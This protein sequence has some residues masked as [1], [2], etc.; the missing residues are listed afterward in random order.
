MKYVLPKMICTK[1]NTIQ[2]NNI[3][4]KC[5]NC[6]GK[7]ELYE[8]AWFGTKD[9]LLAKIVLIILAI[10]MIIY[11][12]EYFFYNHIS[13]HPIHLIAIVLFIIFIIIIAKIRTNRKQSNNKIKV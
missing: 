11:L 10:W 6:R 9:V 8:E 5:K 12:I 1:C 13:L 7:L 2:R 3:K 4:F